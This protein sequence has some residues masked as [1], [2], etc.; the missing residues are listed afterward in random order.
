MTNYY[1]SFS[2]RTGFGFSGYILRLLIRASQVVLEPAVGC[3]KYFHSQYT[4]ENLP[5]GV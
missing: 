5:N 2:E 3:H 4:I 1:G